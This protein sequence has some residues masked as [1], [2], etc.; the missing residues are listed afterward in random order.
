MNGWR[1]AGSAFAVLLLATGSVSG[2]FWLARH[3]EVQDQ[4]YGRPV[5][6]L[7]LDTGGGDVTLLPGG[8]GVIVH[9]HLTWSYAKPTIREVW[10]GGTLRVTVHC[11]LVIVGPLCA[12]N[13]VLRVPATV[14]D[15]VVAT[16][17]GDVAL[18]F[19]AAPTRVQVR[20]GSGDVGV[21]LPAGGYQVSTGSHRN[22]VR[23]RVTRDATSPYSIDIDSSSGE[24]DVGYD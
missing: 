16:S 17:S 21:S 12:V 5:T 2:A 11:A 4:A 7:E 10:E 23:V 14:R 6:R 3:T 8:P 18:R 13:Y 9:R 24:I 15:V 20:T 22:R 1:A 19:A